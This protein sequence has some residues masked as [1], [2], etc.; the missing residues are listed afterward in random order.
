MKKLSI[1]GLF[2]AAVAFAGH[3]HAAVSVTN[4]SNDLLNTILQRYADVASSWSATMVSY[5]SW[6]F[7]GLALLSMTWT[8]GMMALR[9]ADIGEF[10]AE[11]IRFFTVLG[12]FWWILSNGPAISVSITD[13][14][15]QIAAKASGLSNGL[16]PSGIVDI[17]FDI[18]KRVSDGSHWSEP[19]QSAIGI[20]VAGVNLV[21]LAL[22]GVNMLLLLVTSWMLAYGGVFLLGF[23]GARWTSDIAIQFYK[24][25]LGVGVQLFAMILL[26]GIGKSFVDQYYDSL[27]GTELSL[28]ALFLLLLVS[29]VLLALVNKV[30]PMLASIVGGSSTGGIGAFGAGA[31]A[32]AAGSAIGAAGFAVGAASA[33]GSAAMGAASSAAGGASA[34]KAA[35]QSAQQNMASGT[36][37]FSGGSSSSF[38]G[39]GTSGSSSGGSSGF[40]SV[41]GTAGKFAADMGTSLA[42]GAGAVAKD[43]AAGMMDAAKDRIAQTA[44]GKIASAI[45]EGS[46]AKQ[47]AGAD[48]G[49]FTGDSVGGAQS[50]PQSIN[51][52]V[53][54]FVNRQP[55]QDA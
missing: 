29:I 2:L 18:L 52:E 9:K 23:G 21:V 6:L 40:A 53:A 11:T 34:L 20:L 27:K 14:M 37:I 36:G 1:T 8:Y 3:A 45:Q 26:V 30:P 15:R 46:G 5:A 41:F 55:L 35:F 39:S 33:A 12:F 25:V 48:A 28:N 47:Q 49:S 17:G 54:A 4:G 42:Q 10:L 7:W 38:G 51:D 44:G 16:A 31:A 32:A 22:V 19:V 24:T 50:R 43:K 13:S